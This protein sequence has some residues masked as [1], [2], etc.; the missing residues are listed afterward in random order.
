MIGV[1]YTHQIL[2]HSL[3]ALETDWV[4]RLVLHIDIYLRVIVMPQLL[5]PKWLE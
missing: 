2:P 1:L 5:W 3:N 4:T